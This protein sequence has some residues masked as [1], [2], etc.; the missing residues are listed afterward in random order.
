[1]KAGDATPDPVQCAGGCGFF[2]N[3]ATESMCSKCFRDAQQLKADQQA[4]VDAAVAESSAPADEASIF[5]SPSNSPV[6]P[7]RL[8]F[9]NVTITSPL[10]SPSDKIEQPEEKS[11]A[12]P[13][14][15]SMEE[16]AAVLPAEVFHPELSVS[17]A[18]A[19][20]AVAAVSAPATSTPTAATKAEIKTPVAPQAT[21]PKVADGVKEEKKP[22]KKV[23]KNRKR[24][25]HAECKK[26]VGLTGIECK[27]GFVFC[28]SHRWPDQH[29]CDFDFKTHDR[30]NL[31]K[32]VLGGGQF[33]KMQK[34]Q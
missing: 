11:V 19:A 32:T 17:S 13:V 7:T 29:S 9:G 18:A 33:S 20:P 15:V 26:K 31:A 27:C 10:C 30:D 8:S 24:C 1:M 16:Q 2:G 22:K 14:D 25:F 6:G 12:Q 4:R 21:G 5:T 23:Q 3:P 28:S 34:L